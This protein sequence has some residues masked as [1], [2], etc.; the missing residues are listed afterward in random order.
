MA[1]KTYERGYERGGGGGG[2]EREREE[3]LVAPKASARLSLAGIFIGAFAALGLGI[4]FNSLGAAVGLARVNP[5]MG[6]W[7]STGHF[8]TGLWSIVS[9][10]VATYL[11]SMIGVRSSNLFARRDGGVQGL[12]TWALSFVIGMTFIAF[13]AAGTMRPNPAMAPGGAPSA[14]AP[15][16]PGM[17]P[18]PGQAAGPGVTAPTQLRAGVRWWFFGTAVAGMLAGIFGG[19]SGLPAHMQATTRRAPAP[20]LRE[21]EV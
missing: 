14:G 13:L 19:L 7:W 15:A 12:V 10:F 4:L 17:A 2:Y 18:A 1:E 11:G 8:W 21:R 5:L 20:H 6:D 3:L 9:I 16:A